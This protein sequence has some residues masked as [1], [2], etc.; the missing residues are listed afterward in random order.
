MPIQDLAGNALQPVA[1]GQM[2]GYVEPVE[3]ADLL[4]LNIYDFLIWPIRFEDEQHGAF[5]VKRFLAGPQAIWQQ[6]QE[7][8]HGIKDLWDVTKIA[9]E[10]LHLQKRIVGWTKELDVITDALDLPTLRKLIA[11]SIPLW[12]SRG[13]EDA[14]IR[15]LTLATGARTRI[16]NWFDFRYVLGER[17]FEEAH[18]GADPWLIN[19]P[20]PPDSDEYRS[21]IRVVDNGNLNRSLVINLVKLMRAVG[22]RI[23]ISYINF[24]DLFS[25]DGDTSQWDIGFGDQMTVSGGQALLSN[26]S[27]VQLSYVSYDDS[28]RWR[29]LIAYVRVQGSSV[30]ADASFGVVFGYQ[31]GMNHYRVELNTFTNSLRLSKI[32]SGFRSELASSSLLPVDRVLPNIPYGIRIQSLNDSF[33]LNIKVYF[34]GQLLFNV[35]DNSLP[36]A[37]G[38]FGVFHNIGASGVAFDEAEAFKLPLENDTININS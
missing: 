35:I 15:V 34:D 38:S 23:E 26:A 22:E 11:A 8:I 20:G 18:C 12:K 25:V 2:L 28:A 33:G 14:L 9:D 10:Y 36:L 37:F 24:L 30:D 17:A 13:P 16:W 7:R 31:S 27:Q 21:N 4:T 6:I 29:D 32:T 19:L 3:A 5:F 1:S